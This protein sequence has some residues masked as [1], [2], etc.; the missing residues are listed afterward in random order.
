MFKDADIPEKSGSEIL[1]AE[2]ILSDMTKLPFKIHTSEYWKKGLE[3]ADLIDV[4]IHENK[5]MIGLG[6]SPRIIRE[7]GGAGIFFNMM[8]R[9]TKYYLRSK[10]IRHRFKKLSKAKRI[11]VGSPMFPSSTSKYVGY[12]LGVGKKVDGK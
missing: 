11:L 8:I 3:K 12:I 4:E 7:I 1:R 6:E 2:H 5:K 10:K 9:F